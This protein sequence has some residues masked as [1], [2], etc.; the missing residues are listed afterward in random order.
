MTSII[1]VDQIQNAAG[2]TPTAADLG[3]NVS[4]SVLQVGYGRTTAYTLHS[5]SSYTASNLSVTFT[6]KFANSKLIFDVSG[7]FWSSTNSHTTPEYFVAQI[8]DSRTSSSIHPQGGHGSLWFQGTQQDGGNN[9]DRMVYGQTIIDNDSTATRTYTVYV[10][11]YYGNYGIYAFE[12]TA[13]N[14]IRVTEIAG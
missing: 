9:W 1:K 11:S 2:G 7:S 14:I 10:K 5:S 13:D 4:G 12:S 6:P 8:H 3:L